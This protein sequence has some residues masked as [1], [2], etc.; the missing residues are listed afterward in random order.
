MGSLMEATMKKISV[1]IL[2]S[3]FALA[4]Y[5]KAPAKTP[6]PTSEITESNDPAKADAVMQ[7]AN[8]LQAQQDKMQSSGDSGSKKSKK[9]KSHKAKKPDANASSPAA[10]ESK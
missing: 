7:H 4:G 6:S 5:A 2:I 3:L 10:T 1:A 9:H 8:E